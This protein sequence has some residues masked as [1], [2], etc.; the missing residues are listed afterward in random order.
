MKKILLIEDDNKLQKIKAEELVNALPYSVISISSFDELPTI[1][2]EYEN[3]I[4]IVLLDDQEDESKIC[5]TIEYLA[6]KSIPSI[7]YDDKFDA[8]LREKVLEKGA[9][10]YLLKRPNEDLH[11]SMR[12][13]DR[14][15]KNDFIKAIV[16]DG[17]ESFKDEIVHSLEDF[18][19]ITL[20]ASD[21]KETMQLLK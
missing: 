8:Q 20:R 11:Y 7:V 21:A 15:Y 4:F 1:F 19:I 17:L 16:V 9:L 6:A 5:E 3:D 18:G 13:I 12:L 2:Q 14:V 10:E